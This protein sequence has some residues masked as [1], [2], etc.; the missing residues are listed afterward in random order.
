MTF[1]QASQATIMRF[2]KSGF[3]VADVA[4]TLVSFDAERSAA[5]VRKAMKKGR[6]QIVGVRVDGVIA[7]Y[8]TAADLPA[9]GR[10]GRNMHSFDEA[11]VFESATPLHLAIPVLDEAQCVFVSSLGT[12]GG[13]GFRAEVPL[14]RRSANRRRPFHRRCAL[15]PV[16]AVR[17][18]TSR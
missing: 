6:L 4:R 14:G 2:F 18:R 12:V 17:R 7:G 15:L 8:V 9:T 13:L 1:D 11:I 10:C 5:S 16:G 3:T